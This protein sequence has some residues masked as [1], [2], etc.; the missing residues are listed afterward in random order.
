MEDCKTQIPEYLRFVKSVVDA[1]DLNLNFS[2]EILQ[3]DRLLMAL[4]AK[5]EAQRSAP[6][7]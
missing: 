5:M 2:R 6:Y 7:P 4:N 1:P 3:H